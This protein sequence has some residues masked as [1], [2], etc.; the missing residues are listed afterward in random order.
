[1]DVMI[2]VFAHTGGLTG[3][4]VAVAGAAS[5]VGHM[6]LKAVL[7]DQ[8]VRTFRQQWRGAQLTRLTHG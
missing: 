1:M 3:A 5:A 7:G 6:L 4:E 2:L 8:T